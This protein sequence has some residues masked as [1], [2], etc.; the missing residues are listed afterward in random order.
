MRIQGHLGK[1]TTDLK[2]REGKKCCLAH[3]WLYS[4][5]RQAGEDVDALQVPRVRGAGGEGL[6][7][8][9]T[10]MESKQLKTVHLIKTGN[11]R[12]ICFDCHQ[13]G[14]R[15]KE[16]DGIAMHKVLPCL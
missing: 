6:F 16:L 2:L 3:L 5:A 11:Q 15:S 7:L 14:N 12:K 4:L 1:R 10:H 13:G 9:R 8:L